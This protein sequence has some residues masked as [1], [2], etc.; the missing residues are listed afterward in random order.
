MVRP[1][2]WNDLHCSAGLEEVK[3]Q[4]FAGIDKGSPVNSVE[5]DEPLQPRSD[6]S[7]EWRDRLSRNKNEVIHSW[8]SNIR[9]ILENDDAWRDS[10]AYCDFSYRIIKQR[11]TIPGCKVGEW[12]DSDTARLRDWFG[13]VYRFNPSEGEV[14]HALIVAAQNRRFHPVRDYLNSL[15]WDGVNRLDY[16]IS[17][18]LCAVGDPRYLAAVGRK[19]MIGAVA[20]VMHPGCKMDNVLILEG[21]QGLKKST[22]IK[23][24]FGDWFSDSPI[25]LGDKDAYQNIQG[26]WGL[27]LAE[28]DSLN[29]AEST[30]A[31]SFFSQVCDR[32]RPSYGRMAQ[33][34]ERQCVVIGTTNQEEYLKD[35]TGN[36]RYWPV[37]CTSVNIDYLA[38]LRDVLFAEALHLYKQKT[39]WWCDE[40]DQQ[41]FEDEQNKR[42]QIDLWHYKIEDYLRSITCDF[43]TADDVI[44]GA[45]KKDSSHTTK[46]DQARLGPIMRAIGWNKKRRMIPQSN[47]KSRQRHGYEKPDDWV[48]APR[49]SDPLDLD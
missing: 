19:F 2:D 38:E 17:D 20:R 28:L 35:Y 21:T 45:I 7:R 36:R 41:L 13:S 48:L 6:A 14:V 40:S 4:F 18:A 33:N 30:T 1:M 26:V 24:L 34:F 43:V 16:W 23:T 10:L 25:V 15:E 31:K 37:H 5:A 12:E 3:R 29:K 44:S 47:G 27:E 22:A 49:S 11:E 46:A 42:L 32:Y 9:L 8:V 39:I